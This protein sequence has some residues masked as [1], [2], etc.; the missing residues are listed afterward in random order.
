MATLREAFRLLPGP[1]FSIE[2]DPRTV[3][4]ATAGAPGGAR[5]QP[6]ELR[7]AGL[8]PGGAAGGAPRAALRAGGQPDA[9]ARDARIRI[10]QRRPDLRASA[11]DADVAGA[12]RAAGGRI[13]AGPRCALRLRSPAAT[14]QA[15]TAHRRCRPSAG[16]RTHPML[17]KASP[18][19][20]RTATSTSAWTTSR[21]PTTR[22]AVAK[23]QGRLH[24]NFQGYSTQP[25]CDLIAL[26]V[27][28]ISACRRYLQPERQD[29][30]RVLRRA[31]PW[32]IAGRARGLA[33]TREDLRPARRDHG[34]DVPGPRRLS[35]RSSWPTWST[36]ALFRA[37]TRTPARACRRR[38]W[39]G[40]MPTASN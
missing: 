22:L 3:T 23:R 26:G 5:L 16:G 19:S 17:P 29:A 1:R 40:S 33:L 9:A 13:A 32:A 6:H 11:A 24:R 36:C 38:A 39:C 14:L 12:H 2:V 21:C 8:R 34:A 25:D 37:R 35:S 31:A 30:A 7:R 28:S 15:A 4:T 20:S 18:A 27:S 10:D